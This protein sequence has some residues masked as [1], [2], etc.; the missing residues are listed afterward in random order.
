MSAAARCVLPTPGEP[1]RSRFASI[2]GY[3]SYHLAAS[4]SLFSSTSIVCVISSVSMYR[5]TCSR[6]IIAHLHRLRF[7]APVP[8][9][10]PKSWFRVVQLN[11]RPRLFRFDGGFL[12]SARVIIRETDVG[13]CARG[14]RCDSEAGA[15]LYKDNHSASGI[16]PQGLRG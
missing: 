6:A 5:R 3:G 12:P 8:A 1:N 11:S 16:R 15:P 14:S 4:S 13:A 2:S 10:I 9:Y 7:R